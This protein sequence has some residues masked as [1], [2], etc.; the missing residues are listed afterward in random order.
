LAEVLLK[1]NRKHR[2]LSPQHSPPWK[3]KGEF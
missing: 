1:K 3:I 2:L